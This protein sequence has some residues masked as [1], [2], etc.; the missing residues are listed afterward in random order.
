MPFITKFAISYY[1]AALAPF[2]EV[3]GRFNRIKRLIPDCDIWMTGST[4]S[5]YQMT[6]KGTHTEWSDQQCNAHWSFGRLWAQF[7][8][9]L[10]AFCRCSLPKLS[11]QRE[12]WVKTAT[13]WSR[14]LKLACKQS[15]SEKDR[16]EKENEIAHMK[17][18]CWAPA[19]RTEK[20][21]SDIC[22]GWR[23]AQY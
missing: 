10:L 9:H 20:D 23:L 11:L 5:R 6:A 22:F 7:L 4:Q 18:L 2:T 1:F 21:T 13:S 8:S 12:D 14:S 3:P 16:Y 19:R 17:T 15:L